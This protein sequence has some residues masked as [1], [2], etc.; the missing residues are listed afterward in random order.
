[1]MLFLY[2]LTQPVKAETDITAELRWQVVNDTVMGGRSTAQ[3]NTGKNGL[4]FSGNVSLE[5]NGG[6]AS[7]RSQNALPDLSEFNGVTLHAASKNSQSY[8]LVFWI[9]RMGPQLYYSLPFLPTD[10][11]QTFSMYDFQAVSYGRPVSAPPLPQQLNNVSAIGI[12][13]GDKQEGPFTLTIRSIALTETAEVPKP[14]TSETQELLRAV[15]ETGVPLFNDGNPAACAS[16]YRTALTAIL[17]LDGDGLDPK[18]KTQVQSVLRQTE[19][20]DDP[21][22]QAW[23]Y[24]FVI[25]SLLMVDTVSA[26][27]E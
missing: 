20:M 27:S 19:Q 23:A 9:N 12:L 13:I 6:F 11:P 1:M 15:I 26:D 18:Y 22:D 5:N 25:D 7:I 17:L 4:Q 14:P 3:I 8:K 21:S 24:R 2:S 16:A 10:E